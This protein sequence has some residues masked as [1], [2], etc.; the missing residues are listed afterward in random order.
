[1]DFGPTFLRESPSV[2]RRPT[3]RLLRG[4]TFNNQPANVRSANRNRNAPPYRNTNNGFRPAST[5]RPG[6][7][8]ASPESGGG[9]P[10][11]ERAGAKSRPP[12][13]AGR[14]CS[15]G[16]TNPWPGG[17]GRSHDSNAP[18]GRLPLREFLLL[19]NKGTL[20]NPK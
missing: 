12:S 2:G 8:P 14:P 17:S 3:P 20:R 15:P 9:L 16:Q 6:T 11:S 19:A 7:D 5:C 13:R 10:S 4:G 1:M 18:P